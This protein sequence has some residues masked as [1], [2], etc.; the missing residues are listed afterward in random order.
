MSRVLFLLM[1]ALAALTIGLSSAA[2]AEDAEG[3][4]AEAQEVGEVDDAQDPAA[5]AE[6][7]SG[8]DAAAA[9][10]LEP[11]ES[12]FTRGLMIS[13]VALLIGGGS[14]VLGIWVDRDPS[15]PVVFGA[16]MSV[17]ITAAVGVSAVQGYLDS[18][19]NIQKRKD[20]QRMLGMVNEI[21]EASGDPELIALAKEE[22]GVEIEVPEPD[23]GPSNVDEL[24]ADGP[25][26]TPQADSPDP[27]TDAN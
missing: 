1:T 21:A 3:A 9:V 24:A 10:E 26:A 6:P 2:Y 20:L 17:L 18:E 22:N 14:A 5:E 19:E 23:S 27:A 15:R 11:E 12:P 7:E 13:Y 25:A 16:A 8:A 4:A